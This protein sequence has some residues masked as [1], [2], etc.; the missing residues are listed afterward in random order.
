MYLCPFEPSHT[1][2]LSSTSL[3][4]FPSNNRSSTS[5]TFI[6]ATRLQHSAADDQTELR[7]CSIEQ[8]NEQTAA[9]PEH[10][11]WQEVPRPPLL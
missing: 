3:L 7:L 8:T 10:K 11:S 5:S 9:K 6:T 2:I 4:L 1:S